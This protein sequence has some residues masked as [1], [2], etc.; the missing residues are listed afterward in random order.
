MQHWDSRHRR[1]SIVTRVSCFLVVVVCCHDCAAG[2]A[3]RS[4]HQYDSF[5]SQPQ[6]SG[7]S[8]NDAAKQTPSSAVT[9]QQSSSAQSIM[10]STLPDPNANPLAI[11]PISTPGLAGSGRWIAPWQSCNPWSPHNSS[12]N[13]CITP[14]AGEA[15]PL[16]CA[17]GSLDGCAQRFQCHKGCP[18]CI[19]PPVDR[20]CNGFKQI[21]VGQLDSTIAVSNV[22]LGN[23]SYWFEG[24]SIVITLNL[25]A[26]MLSKPLGLFVN[27]T[28]PPTAPP[29]QL[30][31]NGVLNTA[32]ADPRWELLNYPYA[33]C[34]SYKKD[35]S[36][37][38]YG[39]QVYIS[40]ASFSCSQAE[41]GSCGCK[42]GSLLGSIGGN[43]CI[44]SPEPGRKVPTS[45]PSRYSRAPFS[46]CEYVTARYC[47]PG[48]SGGDLGATCV[49][50]AGSCGQ[51]NT[52]GG[53][54]F[55]ELQ[56]FQCKG[57]NPEGADLGTAG[58]CAANAYDNMGYLTLDF[59]CSTT[60]CKA[61]GD[62]QLGY[63]CAS[64]TACLDDSG[65]C[66]S[67]CIPLA[68]SWCPGMCPNAMQYV[69][70]TNPG[71]AYT[72]GPSQL[73]GA[74]LA[75][76]LGAKAGSSEGRNGAS[77]WLRGDYGSSAPV[78]PEVSNVVNIG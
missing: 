28:S 1:G 43:L 58:R 55:P 29:S 17:S 7:W 36:P 21:E 67:R 51:N 3:E 42:D 45:S 69:P 65:M 49:A 52:C 37:L 73:S 61:D 13:G 23:M 10:A 27:K 76:A 64:N 57:F 22:P 70:T 46:G 25:T 50:I 30:D 5:L 16:P 54:A 8:G 63:M 72:P 44:Y 19:P 11:Q 77:K 41:D 4:L 53:G 75:Q 33:S 66:T 18:L 62:C 68:A 56:G 2:K 39:D 31:T 48:F 26:G 71:A 35:L 78:Q 60:V 6:Q 12:L 38:S 47:P 9:A 14:Q 24:T 74:P 15:C 40:L 34:I 20:L 59:T 32:G